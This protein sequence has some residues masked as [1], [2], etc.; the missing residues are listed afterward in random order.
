MLQSIWDAVELLPDAVNA[1]RRLL[2]CRSRFQLTPV[3]YLCWASPASSWRY[4]QRPLR[5]GTPP[6]ADAPSDTTV[7]HASPPRL[8]P[9]THAVAALGR[10]SPEVEQAPSDNAELVQGLQHAASCLS[11]VLAWMPL[12]DRMPVMREADSLKWSALHYAARYGG[13]AQGRARACVK[14]VPA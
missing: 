6:I 8:L 11:E 9:S 7:M 2:S 13:A 1:R 12:D 14:C 5:S 3:M 10:M 4:S